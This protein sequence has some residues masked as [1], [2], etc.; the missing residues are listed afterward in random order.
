[1]AFELTRK[2]KKTSDFDPEDPLLAWLQPQS[3]RAIRGIEAAVQTLL[4]D[5]QCYMSLNKR[6]VNEVSD[7]AAFFY[8][9]IFRTVRKILRPFLTSNPTW[10][11]RP[12]SRRSRLR[13]GAATVHEIFRS[14]LADMIPTSPPKFSLAT[15]GQ[16]VIS[17]ASSQKLPLANGSIDF[18][19]GSPPYCTRIDYAIA[20]SPEL[21]LLGYEFDTDFYELRRKLIGTP[22]VP[23]AA[24]KASTDLG[25]TCLDF[26]AALSQHTSKASSTYY[27][28]N[29]V[30]Y[31]QS[32]G[33]SL[34]EIGRVLKPS[35]RCVLV[36]QDSYYK[37]V[38]NDLPA[39]LTEMAEIRGLRL[40]DRNNFAHPRTLAGIN[41]GTHE[42][43]SS[44]SAVESVL[45]FETR[46]L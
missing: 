20:T 2:A 15:R 27:Y 30:Q 21:A 31:F 43:R 45:V 9:G 44:F 23:S 18:V 37:D 10:I 41:P 46:C 28:K 6:G 35:G 39:I 5:D 17:V 42:Y 32:I 34:S 36:V 25:K 33:S 19:L 40:R 24:P 22:T 26:L 11:K 1:M 13:P 3:V 16:K 4:I 14:N 8:V 7:L 12:D 38:H 29:H